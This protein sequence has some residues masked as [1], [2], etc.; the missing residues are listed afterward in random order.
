MIGAVAER[1][2]EA[3]GV[4]LVVAELGDR[5][6]P[7]VVLLHGYPD[8]KEV[9]EEVAARLASRFHVV[10][11]DM[12]GAGGSTA[13]GDTAGYDLERLVDDFVAVIDQVVPGR[14]VHLVGHDWGSIS[15]W[16][17]VTAPRLRGRVLSF[18]SISGPSLDHSAH[19]FRARLRRPTPGA[20]GAVLGQLGRSWYIAAFQLPVLPELTWRRV[21]ARRWPGFLRR[22]DGVPAGAAVIAPTFA[23]DAAQGV[24]LYRR[25]MLRRLNRPRGDALAHAPVQLVVARR[26]PFVSPRIFDDLDRWAPVLRRRTVDAGHWLPRAHPAQLAGWISEFVSDVEAGHAVTPQGRLVLVTGAGSGIGRATALAF[27]QPGTRVLAVDVDLAA[28]ERTAELV[29]LCGGRAWALG[30]DV[31]D[32]DAMERLDRQVFEEHGVVDVLVNNAGIGVAGSFLDTGVEEWRR[33][34]DVNLWGVLH[35]CRLVGR[36]MVDRGSGGHIVNVASAAAFTPSKALP[37]YSTSKA[38]VL[39][40]SECL[41]AELAPHGIGVSAICPGF[42][43]TNITRSTRFVGRSAEEQERLRDRSTRLYRRRNYPPERVAAAIVRAVE[44]DQAVVPVTVE[45]R[46][47]Q[48][49]GRLVPGVVRRL[50]RLDA[51]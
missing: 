49:L 3:L 37:A 19:W 50:A 27:A 43:S 7:T 31:S 46:A 9:W 29:R 11:Y 33:V 42:V 35:G 22:V 51:L 48:L 2:V 36:R 4:R 32:Q 25:N 8:T 21:M 28:A 24:G 14:A 34:L 23:T 16:D 6:A 1:S 40:M 10:A 12:R 39:M 15:G 41:R 44:R 30:C 17:M 13:P 26:D 20:L 18:T 38:A 47:M 5:S 45:A